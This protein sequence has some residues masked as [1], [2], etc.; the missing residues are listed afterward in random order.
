MGN[1]TTRALG[2]EDLD[3]DGD[4][5][6]YAVIRSGGLSTL[7]WAENLGN[8]Q[9]APAA[10]LFTVATPTGYDVRACTAD[11]DGDGDAD[12]VVT[13]QGVTIAENV[14]GA[15][16]AV[17]P[18]F[19]TN[20]NLGDVRAGDLDG[21]GDVDLA[22][23]N[24]PAYGTGM[25]RFS[26]QGSFVFSQSPQLLVERVYDHQFV[27]FD[28]DGDLDVL[29]S[30]TGSAGSTASAGWL[31]NSGGGVLLPS[32]GLLGGGT[33]PSVD[34]GDLDGDG[35][36]DF[37]YAGGTQGW[38]WRQQLGFNSKTFGP[39]IWLTTQTSYGV[40]CADM[41]N[42][43]DL[44]V[45]SI[46]AG[47]T[48]WSNDRFQ[49]LSSCIDPNYGTSLGSASD[50]IHAIQSMGL[51]FALNGQSYTDVHISDHGV[52][53]LS[54][55]GVPAPPAA[56]PTVYN[57]QLSDMLANGP[58]IACFW[59][60]ATPGNANAPGPQG[61]VFINNSDPSKCVITWVGMYTYVNQPPAYTFQLTLLPG[62]RIKMAWDTKVSNYGSTFAPNAIIGVTPGGVTS[63][64][65]SSDL[66]GNPSVANGTIFEEFTAPLSFD[67]R[68]RGLELQQLLPP[69]PGMGY[70]WR[71]T[72]LGYCVDAASVTTYG[73][74][75]VRQSN[76]V[77][78]RFSA[79]T[80]DLLGTVVDYKRQSDRYI[81]SAGTGSFV[82]PSAAAVTVAYGDD[83]YQTVTLSQPVPTSI[84]PTDQ[85]TIGS[86]GMVQFGGAH[87]P[88]NSGSP[89]LMTNAF[90]LP[91][92]AAMWHDF[93]PTA[94]GSGQILFEE[95]AGIAY[96]T[97]DDV[98]TWNTNVGETFQVQIRL[99]TGDVKVL[100]SAVHNNVGN[101][102]TVGISTG[103]NFLNATLLP[104]PPAI[105]LTVT[106]ATPT[107]ASDIG[108]RPME[109][110][111]DAPRIGF[112]WTLS[113]RFGD[114]FSPLTLF[115]FGSAQGPG[116]PLQAIGFNAP[117]CTFWLDAINAT[118]VAP[119]SGG[120]SSTTVT[121][122]F[123]P[124]FQGLTFTV[125]A[126]AFTTL[127]PAG[128]MVSNGV[129]AVLGL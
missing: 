49:L 6:V 46:S 23:T 95:I 62:G 84:G 70:G 44:D 8:G 80:F 31:E 2:A 105:D 38:G 122:P 36:K 43:L 35:D 78:E 26:N 54:N 14:G 97:W 104:Q 64:P 47:Y 77:F 29:W 22:I 117:G 129:E 58:C 7:R 63:A 24:N 13:S 118:L 82:Q 69:L 127:N 123:N 72:P 96:V 107:P 55:A 120:Q 57:V 87:G 103:T 74:G 116:V 48:V 34:M 28:G 27:D 30:G 94:P 112:P 81:V 111:A 9:F 85:L 108:A 113:S 65:P 42:D 115:H 86:N 67:L 89:G 21:D 52:V 37:V 88:V 41:D 83:T 19:A 102:Y 128:W 119:Q 93:D 32:Q 114:P 101:G 25:W 12:I 59:A 20:L 15:A 71:A 66:S 68:G 106:L 125:Q 126:A 10:S 53:W 56:T 121:V 110:D 33:V 18:A 99:A 5:D 4:L 3:G 40:E 51:A 39:L 76:T 11:V 17:R 50:T 109:L 91:T 1:N 79:G 100:Y 75:C 61:E 73:E 45:V 92:V 60:D 124:V 90:D 16:F 98:Y